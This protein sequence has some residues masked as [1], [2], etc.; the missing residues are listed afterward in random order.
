MAWVWI[1]PPVSERAKIVSIMLV[2]SSFTQESVSIHGVMK[3]EGEM[4]G[5]VA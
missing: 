2:D 1:I 5:V 3:E 4:V